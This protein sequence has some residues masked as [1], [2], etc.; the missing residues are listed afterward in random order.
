MIKAA[1]QVVNIQPFQPSSAAPADVES[2][3]GG[4]V[5]ERAAPGCWGNRTANRPAHQVCRRSQLLSSGTPPSSCPCSGAHE[6]SVTYSRVIRSGDED[7]SRGAQVEHVRRQAVL[8]P[9]NAARRR[10]RR[11]VAPNGVCAPR[12]TRRDRAVDGRTQPVEEGD[13]GQ[14]EEAVG[15][16]G[17]EAPADSSPWNTKRHIVAASSRSRSS[18]GRPPRAVPRTNSLVSTRERSPTAR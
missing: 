7:R 11:L 18:R 12:R 5:D 14:V 17:V 2:A 8:S 1:R 6:A 3:H 9:S 13:D 16:I 15:Q 10:E 4:V